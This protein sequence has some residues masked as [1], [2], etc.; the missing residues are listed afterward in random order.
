MLKVPQSLSNI[1]HSQMLVFG[2]LDSSELLLYSMLRLPQFFPEALFQFIVL[3]FY[4]QS[5]VIGFSDNLG[6][7]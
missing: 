5:F 1:F 6:Y 3:E 7:L 4:V 2:S